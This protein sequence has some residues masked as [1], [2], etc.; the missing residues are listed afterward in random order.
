MDLDSRVT[1]LQ[2]FCHPVNRRNNTGLDSIWQIQEELLVV[3]LI[4]QGLIFHVN[5]LSAGMARLG[6]DLEANELPNLYYLCLD[7]PF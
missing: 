6:G 2:S 5:L 4:G 3:E 7:I 1:I